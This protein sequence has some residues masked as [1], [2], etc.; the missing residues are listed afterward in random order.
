M[1]QIQPL[2]THC[3]N[4][5]K[6][7]F[8]TANIFALTTGVAFAQ[9]LGGLDTAKSTL[10]SIKTYLYSFLGIAA[11]IYLMWVA[12]QCFT[13]KKQ[14]GDLGMAVVQVTVVGAII[15]LGSWAWSLFGGTGVTIT[16]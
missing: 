3:V 8:V 9:T 4:S 5:A 6:T 7:A 12:I 2:I 1:K 15:V 16:P 14:W 11:M 13:E 10:G